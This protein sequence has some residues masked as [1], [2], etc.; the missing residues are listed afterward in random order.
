MV[1]IFR[2]V[3]KLSQIVLLKLGK[4]HDRMFDHESN[5]CSRLK[6]GHVQLVKYILVASSFYLL[7]VFILFMG[8]A[9]EP[10]VSRVLVTW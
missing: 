5:L 9:R 6:F 3:A 8:F 1:V 10:L 7:A 4:S 2:D